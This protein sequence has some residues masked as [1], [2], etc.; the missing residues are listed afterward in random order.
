MSQTPRQ[1]IS[2]LGG[3]RAVAKRLRVSATTM[4]GY[5]VA[6]LLPPKWYSALLAL[7][8]ER[9]VE[10]PSRDLFSFE[11]LPPPEQKQDVA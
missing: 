11:A 4:H 6:G 5:M 2:T 8:A 7:A 9:A 1:F 3:Y 10:P